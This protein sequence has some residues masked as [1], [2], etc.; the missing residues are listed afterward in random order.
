MLSENELDTLDALL[1]A[2]TAEDGLLLSGVDGFF[3]GVV[4]CPELVMPGEWLPSIWGSS[5]DASLASAEEAQQLTN[6]LMRHYNDVAQTLA[7][8]SAIYSPLFD[9]D[10]RSGEILWETW[11]EGFEIAMRFR[12]D[13]WQR[14]VESDDE[15]A[16]SAV[17]MAL[18]LSDIARGRSD[19]STDA[20]VALT[21]NAPDIIPHLVV[22]LNAWTKAETDAPSVPF[23]AAANQA[24]APFHGNKV[25]RNAPCPCGSGR[26]YKR[27]CGGN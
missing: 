23:W 8:S 12:P 26:K 7:V 14:I 13:A 1:L 5:G 16:A 4:V 21:Q 6:L 3:A 10:T 20:I 25:G 24:E 19:L 18:A 15:E 9:E 2:R 11:C 27:C 17:N 22:T